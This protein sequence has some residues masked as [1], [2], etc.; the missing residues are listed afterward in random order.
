MDFKSTMIS[1]TRGKKLLN[2]ITYVAYGIT[3]FVETEWNAVSRARRWWELE[4]VGQRAQ[5]CSYEMSKFWG[6]IV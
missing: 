2:G 6:S 3:E 4:Y 1:E 5:T